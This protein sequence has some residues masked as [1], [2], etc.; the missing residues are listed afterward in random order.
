MRRQV[1]QILASLPVDSDD[2]EVAVPSFEH[3]PDQTFSSPDSGYGF[4][5]QSDGTMRSSTSMHVQS[6]APTSATA[7]DFEHGSQ[8]FAYDA[9]RGYP[10]TAGNNQLE[11]PQWGMETTRWVDLQ[12][13][14]NS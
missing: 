13:H 8:H 2:A 9:R 12:A 6:W 4:P 3:V 10:G 14:G 11:Y 1:L 7:W 5:F